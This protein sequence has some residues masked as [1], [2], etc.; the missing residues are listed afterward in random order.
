MELSVSWNDSFVENNELREIQLGLYFVNKVQNHTMVSII[1][2]QRAASRRLISFGVVALTVILGTGI[3][4]HLRGLWLS[5]WLLYAFALVIGIIML[6]D[7]W[8]YSRFKNTAVVLAVNL[9]LGAITT[10]EG[11]NAGAYLYIIPTIF[12]LVFMLG[13]TREYRAEV[14]GYFV[15]SVLTFAATILFVPNA[16]SWQVISDDIYKKM[17]TTN[18]IAVVVLC[19]VFAYI[20]IYFERKVYER[21]INERNKARHQ[22]QMIREQNGYLRE[23]A[24]MSSHTVRAPLSNILGLASLMRD[25]PNDPDTFILVKEGIATAAQDLD[26]AIHHMVSK[27]G[28]LIKR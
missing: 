17:F 3:T 15:V 20:G 1:S 19:A 8:G 26:K 25:V 4:N 23:I 2:R 24:F 11:L 18:A 22:E 7:Y 5:A 6:L 12:A 28:N 9:F 10:V 21:L 27:T 13:N 14:I 16:S